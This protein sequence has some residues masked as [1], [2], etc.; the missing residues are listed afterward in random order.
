MHFA[1]ALPRRLRPR[2]YL[3]YFGL[4]AQPRE[5]IGLSLAEAVFGTPSVLLNKFLQLDEFSVDSIVNNLNKLWML[6]LFLC[7]GTSQVPNCWLSCQMSCCAPLHVAWQYRPA[8]PPPYHGPYAVL[9]CGPRSFTIMVGSWEEIVS[10][11]RLKACRKVGTTPGSPRRHGQLPGKCPGGP[12]ATKRV[13][14][15]DPLVSSPVFTAAV[16][17]PSAVT[18]L[19]I[20][21]L[22]SPPAGRRWSSG[23][24][25]W[26]PAMPLVDGQ[27]S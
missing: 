3:L 15:S 26:R 8:S 1:H 4:C 21:P 11:S 13:S 20:G 19:E 2:S 25:L 5:E 24:A 12:A 27:T 18:T 16:P 22:T 10:V 17:A 7:P 14:F 9:W 23:P 6:L